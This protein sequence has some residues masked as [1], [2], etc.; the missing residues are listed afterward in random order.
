MLLEWKQWK[1]IHAAMARAFSLTVRTRFPQVTQTLVTLGPVIKWSNMS[2]WLKTRRPRKFQEA[3]GEREPC[4]ES[5]GWTPSQILLS[6]HGAEWEQLG[7]VTTLGLAGAKLWLSS[8][9]AG[10]ATITVSFRKMEENLAHNCWAVFAGAAALIAKS[11]KY[12]VV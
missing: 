3:Q 7:D 10:L 9:R 2:A 11:Q 5:H 1:I 4:G 12:W 6:C 8:H